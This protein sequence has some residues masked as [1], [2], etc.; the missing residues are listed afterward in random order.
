MLY[1]PCNLHPFVSVSV[2]ISES[3]PFSIRSLFNAPSWRMSLFF[4]LLVPCQS[5]SLL[6]FLLNRLN[7]T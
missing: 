5:C 7:F 4:I 2:S 6:L 1:I 3:C